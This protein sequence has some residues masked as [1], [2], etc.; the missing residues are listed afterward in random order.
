[1]TAEIVLD[2]LQSRVETVIVE[3]RLLAQDVAKLRRRVEEVAAHLDVRLEVIERQG[4]D[5]RAHLDGL[6]A[7]LQE[8]NREIIAMLEAKGGAA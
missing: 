8:S 7:G 6:L 4:A 5:L 1:M 3:S 2:V